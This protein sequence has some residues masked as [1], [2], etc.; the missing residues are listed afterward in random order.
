MKPFDVKLSYRGRSF[1]TV[2]LEVGHD[3]VGDT[4][5]AVLRLAP[6]LPLLFE[7]L[8]L[9]SPSPVPVLAVH[10]QVVQKLHACTA[11][12]VSAHMTSSTSRSS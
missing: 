1:M 12:A 4:A 8:G 9:E 2:P 5:D 10:H 7:A 11:P 6:D 3:E